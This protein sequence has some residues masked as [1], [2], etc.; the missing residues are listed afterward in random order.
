VIPVRRRRFLALRDDR[1]NWRDPNMPVLLQHRVKGLVTVT[2]VFASDVAQHKLAHD[3]DPTWR[4]DPT[5]DLKRGRGR[6]Q[7]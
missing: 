3:I 2:P 5:Y 4:E 6:C 1:P 7:R